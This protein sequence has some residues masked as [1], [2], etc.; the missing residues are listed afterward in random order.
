MVIT[1][2]DLEGSFINQGIIGSF[3][4]PDGISVVHSTITGVLSNAAT[5][6]IF[7]SRV[8]ISVFDSIVPNIV[9][10]GSITVVNGAGEAAT[11]VKV[12]DSSAGS[13]ASTITNNGSMTV[14]STGH[15]VSTTVTIAGAHAIGF[16]QS[17][18]SSGSSVTEEVV[19]NG[20]MTVNATAF[21]QGEVD[22]AG[23]GATGSKQ[24]ANAHG[25]ASLTAVNT[26]AFNVNVQATALG[27][28]S[29]GG[30]A[31]ASGQGK[32]FVQSGVSASTD[33]E[34]VT[35]SGMV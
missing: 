2:Y 12:D 14:T 18:S 5:G 26:A 20:T 4:A 21:A 7:A 32:G 15:A 19:N 10:N 1:D 27:D 8:G 9:N 11:G 23:A 25:A 3:T 33:T 30:L 31:I 6:K 16:N 24:T 34:S 35:N 28:G 13:I 29:P 17:G 22:L